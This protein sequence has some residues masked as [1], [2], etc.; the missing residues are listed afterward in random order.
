M[1]RCISGLLWKGERPHRRWGSRYIPAGTRSNEGVGNH[2]S[3]VENHRSKWKVI[4]ERKT[5]DSNNGKKYSID[6]TM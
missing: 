4:L 1:F 2:N 5:M 6:L 3:Q